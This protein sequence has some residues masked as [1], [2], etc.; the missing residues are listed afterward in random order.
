MVN[1]CVAIEQYLLGLGSFAS[2]NLGMD[3]F[4]R[5]LE[6]NA[7]SLEKRV[8]RQRLIRQA[9]G[10][11]E[12][13]MPQH[14][15]AVLA[16]WDDPPSAE[17]QMEYLRGEALRS[18]QRYEEAV[19]HL[20]RASLNIVDDVHIWLALGWCYKRTGRLDLAIESLE[21]ALES[22]PCEAIIYYN[23]A[24]YWSLAQHKKHALS[25]LS[26]ALEIDDNFRDLVHDESD[27]DTIRDDPDFRDLTSVIA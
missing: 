10:Y 21:S 12:L 5:D 16:R 20:K 23:L 13:G 14:T 26:R 8:R 11:L 3:H 4:V 25:Y 1:T 24:C 7:M 15:L 6:L 22:E 27:F 17:P 19:A 2:Y 18:L 9:E